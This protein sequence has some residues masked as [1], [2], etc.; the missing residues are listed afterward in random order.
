MLDPPATSRPTA[1]AQARRLGEEIRASLAYL[2]DTIEI[3]RGDHDLLDAWILTAALDA[4]MAPVTRDPALMAIYGGAA[5]STPDALRRPVSVNAVAQSLALPFE[6]VRRRVARLARVGLCVVGP[7]GVVVPNA[8]VTTAGY[9]AQMRGRYDRA[10]LFHH[11][12]KAAG[13]LPE[14]AAPAPASASMGEPPLRAMNWALSEYVLRACYDLIALT[15]ALVASRVLLELV[16]SNIED[17]AAE[18]LPDWAA[19]PAR[20]GRAAR[21]A[22]LARTLRVPPE[23]VRRHLNGLE[24]EGFCLRRDDGWVATAAPNALPRLSAMAEANRA[25]LKRL[26]ARLRALGVLAAWEAEA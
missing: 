4:N 9:E 7:Q 8:A 18:T 16:L 13:A 22:T 26:F 20:V 11:D 15:G 1:P 25:N 14:D 17:L 6:T 23:T 5:E 12:L 2:R 21:T 3:T 24:T 10:R 19:D